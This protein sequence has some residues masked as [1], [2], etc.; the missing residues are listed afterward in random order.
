MKDVDDPWLP[1]GYEV[2]T[3]CEQGVDAT[4]C[5]SFDDC[6]SGVANWWDAGLSA[7][8][9]CFYRDKGE[10]RPYCGTGQCWY[11]GDCSA[12]SSCV[13][14]RG[15][16]GAL[17][18]PLTLGSIDGGY[19][20]SNAIA[21]T[22]F[23]FAP[24]QLVQ[25]CS[26]CGTPGAACAAGWR[27]DGAAVIVQV[28]GACGSCGNGI[29]EPD[30]LET[31]ATCSADCSCGDGLCDL[32][33]VGL[34]GLDCGACD[35]SGCEQPIVPTAWSSM[36]ACGDGVC[37]T[38]GTIP[39]DCV[40]CP[41]DCSGDTDGDGAPDSCEGCPA[42][43]DK[44][45][46]GL[47]GCG[48]ADSDADA[49]GLVLCADNCPEVANPDQA[50]FDADLVGDACDVDD[51]GDGVLDTADVYPFSDLRRWV[52]ID[53]VLVRVE[54]RVLPTGAS[55]MDLLGTAIDGAA[56]HGEFVGDVALL[57]GEWRGAGMIA[58]AEAGMIVSTAARSAVP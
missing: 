23:G 58:T 36:S 37:Q 47:C 43:P 22:V 50:D 41:L 40:N 39:E 34:C 5:A 24:Q 2:G 44:T 35:A 1:G 16:P 6:F 27:P 46:P 56:S 54:N 10:V 42:D 11:A 31:G 4:Y 9:R 45:E 57:V 17:G 20:T 25:P 29:C 7:D 19:C 32:S 18:A 21:E 52:V 38:E 30:L 15:F 13:D 48:V 28:Q 49:D 8:F 55:F 12:G 53:G 3:P 26:G 33:E 51:D 14:S